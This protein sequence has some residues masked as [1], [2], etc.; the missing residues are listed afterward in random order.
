MTGRKILLVYHDQR[1]DLT[2]LL[3]ESEQGIVEG[4][5]NWCLTKT[6]QRENA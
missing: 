3:I 4:I 1:C 5:S 6:L 2:F